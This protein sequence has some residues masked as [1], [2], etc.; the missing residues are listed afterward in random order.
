MIFSATP[1]DIEAHVVAVAVRREPGL[2]TL[3]IK[4]LATAAERESRVRVQAALAAVRHDV[5]R[6][7]TISL[8][9]S[10]RGIDGTGLDL[11]VALAI[12]AT[13]ERPIGAVGELSLAG[14][15]RAV[16]GA[17]AAVEALKQ[18]TSVVLVAPEN[19]EEAAL[20]GDISVVV[21]R[22]LAE[23]LDYLAGTRTPPALVRSTSPRPQP[24]ALDMSDIRGQPLARRA[25][26]VAAAGGHHL[27]L[28]GPPG[29]GKTMLAR[30]LIGILPPLTHEEALDVTRVHSSAGLNVGGGLITSRP[31]RAPHHSTTPPGL[32]GGGAAAPRPGEVTLAHRGVLF[33]DELPEFSRATLECLREPIANGEVLLSR[34][35]G[36]LRF[37]AQCLLVSAAA[38]CP[39]GRFPA[40]R[41]RCSAVDRER[42]RARIPPRL[43]ELF[44][45]RVSL[46]AVDLTSLERAPLGESS[47]DVTRRVYAA[48]SVRADVN[49]APSDV[50]DA[51][52]RSLLT[53][54]QHASLVPDRTIH[55]RVV[56]VSRTI[57]AL[58][59]R[60]IVS[61][62][63]V[64]EALEL[65]TTS[66]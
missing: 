1:R 49:A 40:Q 13:T 57:A 61:E 28:V 19:A 15:V 25:L 18:H 60:A 5:D 50:L 58:E 11:A 20:V 32:V 56:R 17:L 9:A 8:N 29:A 55:E 39:C 14:D 36:A 51:S 4:G 24:L 43:D 62:P 10:G 22:S 65:S 34:A 46:T 31:F 33:L 38:A 3:D 27:R 12:A 6:R 52:A 26:E 2:P 64:A 41:C 7:I 53:R 47:A 35:S 63:H 30:R 66:V 21:V 54:A 48:R 37:P 16:R 23:A 42:Y 44:D 59:G 45:V